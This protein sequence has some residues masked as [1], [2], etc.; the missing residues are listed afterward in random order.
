[1]TVALRLTEHRP[2]RGVR[3]TAAQAALL[4][5]SRLVTVTPEP[6]GHWCV[7][8]DRE[9][10]G[11]VRL[12]S[13]GEVIDLVITPKLPVRRLFFLLGYAQGGMRWHQEAVDVHENDDLLPVVAHAFA[14]MCERA[15]GQGVLQGYRT[16][17]ESAPVLRGRLRT[18]DQ[19][20]RR[21]GQPL[22]AEIRYDDHTTDIAENRILLT[23]TRKLLRTPG[24]RAGTRA[25][26]RRV[27]I[28]LEGVE[29]LPPGQELPVWR[30]SRLNTRFQGPLRLAELVLRSGS[31]EFAEDRALR[32]EG[33]VL[34]MWQVFEDFVT[35]ALADALRARGGRCLLQDRRFHLDH[36][37][38]AQLRPDLVYEPPDAAGPTGV[39]D[40]KYKRARGQGGHTGDLYQMLAYC[41]R[42]GLAEGH[43]VYAAGPGTTAQ[44]HR[45]HGSPGVTVHQHVLD[46]DTDPETLLSQIDTIAEAVRN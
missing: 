5:A 32:A 26:L 10:V 14:R 37:H 1:M 15:L 44:Q 13:R 40:V 22:P 23:A 6:E 30:P 24:T 31:Y 16:V 9:M 28:R 8:A 19:A 45:L 34:R 42:L 11:S 12:T 41:T 20:R 46:L 4:T 39:V 3:L 25:L 38:T 17:E 29:H 7:S 36:A 2:R 18:T 43:L 27:L 21:F 35:H 33:L